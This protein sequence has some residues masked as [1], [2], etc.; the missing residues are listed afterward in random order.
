MRRDD[1]DNRFDFHTNPVGSGTGWPN[2]GGRTPLL[3]E[4]L[5]S[6]E[7]EKR[8]VQR[9]ADLL[10]TLF[11]SE[12]VLTR[13]DALA[14]GIR[15]EMARHLSRW[16][17]QGIQSRAFGIAHKKKDEPLTV[18]HWEANVE[19][20]REFARERP[21]KLRQ[22]LIEH[23]DLPGGFASVTLASSDL[24]KGTVQINTIALDDSPWTGTYF[25]NFPPTLTAQPKE[26]ARFVRWSG[27]STSTSATI[28]LP[29]EKAT[30]SVTAIF[31]ELGN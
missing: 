19:S 13:I 3:R 31:E 20:M 17:W 30:V 10:N 4:M 2:R 22:D 27:G 9:C 18:A 7:F 1:S 15:P 8:F 6:V 23:F 12:R 28:A 5:E 25:R 16:S 21:E 24:S 29:L 11:E 26:G 14:G